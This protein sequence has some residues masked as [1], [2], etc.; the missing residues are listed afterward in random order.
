MKCHCGGDLIAHEDGEKAGTFHCN[1]CGCCM[2]EDGEQRPGHS[3]CGKSGIV[4]ATKEIPAKGVAVEAVEETWGDGTT[5]E[6]FEV[7]HE[8][9]RG[10]RK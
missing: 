8:K 1:N 6:K 5:V 3:G 7:V 10:R 2:S 9:P 4:T